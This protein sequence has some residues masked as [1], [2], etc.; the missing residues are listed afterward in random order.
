MTNEA[1]DDLDLESIGASR[2]DR[3]SNNGTQFELPETGGKAVKSIFNPRNKKRAVVAIGVVSSLAAVA[4]FSV[5]RTVTEEKPVIGSGTATGGIT[6]TV[7]NGQPSE[8]SKQ[9]ADR[10]NNE[11]L[12]IEQQTDPSAHPIAVVEERTDDHFPRARSLKNPEKLSESGATTAETDGHQNSNRATSS[13]QAVYSQDMKTLVTELMN[14]EKATPQ[15]RSVS[16]SYAAPQSSGAR[17]TV[18]NYSNNGSPGTSSK[19]VDGELPDQ[20]AN[21]IIRAGRQYLARAIT[22]ANSD[23]GGEVFVEILNGP[24]RLHRMIGAFEK[25][26]DWLRVEFKSLVGKSDPRAVKAIGLDLE[27]S[28]NAV[29]GDVDNH[30]LYRYG[31]WGIGAAM[32]AV[33]KAAQSNTNTETVFVGDNVVQNT[34][35][36]SARELKMMIGSLG[37]SMGDVFTNR[38]NRPSTISLKV[39]DQ[40]GIVFMTDVCGDK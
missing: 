26:E 12:L 37:E 36:D 1:I 39:N 7:K 31:W 19:V 9:E 35:K 27:T 18:S 30:T 23:I 22:A 34:T 8:L 25:K 32:K 28:L 13:K 11:Q 6:R 20:C 3:I 14:A 5:Y 24:L 4:A 21:P 17:Q 38:I 40:M 15:Y 10:F 2:N 33:G 16:W 29:A